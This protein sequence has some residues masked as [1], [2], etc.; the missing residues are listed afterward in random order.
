MGERVFVS[1]EAGWSGKHRQGWRN[2]FERYVYSIIGLLPMKVDTASAMRVTQQPLDG[3]TSCWHNPRQRHERA[4]GA[5]V[6]KI[7]STGKLASICCR[8]R[9]RY[10]KSNT[11]S[12]CLIVSDADGNLRARTSISARALEF[13]MLDGA[14][15]NE[16][17]AAQRSEFDLAS[18]RWNVPGERMRVAGRIS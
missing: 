9:P 1:Y 10:T 18:A 8:R 17:L 16:V 7:R 15:S 6:A 4:A 3:T 11:A 5:A 13:T 12:P 14:R 2:T